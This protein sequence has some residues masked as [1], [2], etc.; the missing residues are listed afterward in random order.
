MGIV[1]EFRVGRKTFVRDVVFFIISASFSIIFLMDG[2]L[3]MWECCVM[4]GFYL[5][6]VVVVVVWHW[7]LGQKRK[8]REREAAARGHYLAMTNEVLEEGMEVSEEDG[9]DEDAPAGQRQ[10]R[11]RD[12]E[13]FAAL[14]RGGSPDFDTNLE[15]ESDEDG[16][17]GMQLAAEMASSMRVI[18]PSGIRRN[19]IT[20][21]RPS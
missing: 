14:E 2:A 16:E 15:D 10:G 12:T 5:F 19:T 13:D 11:Y 20:P 1:R 17:Q 8:R 6:Y 18:R 3:H 21:I 9:D 7:Y 4:I